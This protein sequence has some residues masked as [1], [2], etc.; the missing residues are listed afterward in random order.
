MS[1]KRYKCHETMLEIYE[2]FMGHLG[3]I[4]G[5]YWT[6]Q[7]FYRGANGAHKGAQTRHIDISQY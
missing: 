6:Y 4:S 5:I 3:H 1:R 7:T 2:T